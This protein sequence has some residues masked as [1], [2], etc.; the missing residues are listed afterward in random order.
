MTRHFRP[1]NVVRITIPWR[2]RRRIRR[3]FALPLA[4]PRLSGADQA[5]RE[6]DVFRAHPPRIGDRG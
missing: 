3:M 2:E 1:D 6:Y 5:D 4:Q